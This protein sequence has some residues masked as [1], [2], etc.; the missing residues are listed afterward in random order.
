MT[1]PF[2]HTHDLGVEFSRSSYLP[3]KVKV[4]NFRKW[5]SGMVGPID[6]ERKGCESIIHDHDCVTVTFVWPCWGG[7]I[8]GIVTGVTSHLTYPVLTN[9][10]WPDDIIEN[11]CWPEEISMSVLYSL[12]AIYLL[13]LN[14]VPIA[15]CSYILYHAC[16]PLTHTP[17][18]II[19]VELMDTMD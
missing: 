2:D 1:L 16:V 18:R 4:W 19:V 12:D 13:C 8:Y 14:L 9:F 15:K 17:L 10:C 11:G 7:Q 5:K 6:M 3:C